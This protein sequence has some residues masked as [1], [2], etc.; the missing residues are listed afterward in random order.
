MAEAIA[1][2]G[3]DPDSVDPWSTD[4]SAASP[5]VPAGQARPCGPTGGHRRDRDRADRTDPREKA[6]PIEN[7]DRNEPTEPDRTARSR[8]IR[9]TGTSPWTRSTTRSAR[10]TT[11]IANRTCHARFM[12]LIISHRPTTGTTGEGHDAVTD[13]CRPSS[14]SPTSTRPAA[15]MRVSRP[16]GPRWRSASGTGHGESHRALQWRRAVPRAPG[17][18]RRGRGAV[19]TPRSTGRRRLVAARARPG[20][21]VGGAPRHA[22]T[23]ARGGAPVEHRR[24]V[25]PDGTTVHWRCVGVDTAWD[26]PW[27]CAFMAWDDPDLHPA[28]MGDGTVHANGATAVARL[29]VGVPDRRP[30]STGWAARARWRHRLG[31]WRL[32]DRAR[33]P[34]LASPNG[35]IPVPIV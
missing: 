13:W 35:P 2:Y 6:E 1:R 9:S 10:T 11:T 15:R 23:A 33:A 14:S 31:G 34:A 18:R 19:L 3:I 7:A 5:D 28:R 20:P 8:S 27:R 16:D 30:C 17:R 26:E 29:D 12:A 32:R 24:R 4:R 22:A 21:M 25:L